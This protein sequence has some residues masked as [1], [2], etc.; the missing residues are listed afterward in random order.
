MAEND[1]DLNDAYGLRSREDILRYYRTLAPNYD[2]DFAK[3]MDFRVPELIAEA[4]AAEAVGPVLDVGAGTGLL[5]AELRQR[6]VAPIDGIDISPEMI[7]IARGKGLYRKLHQADVTQPLN[8]PDSSYVGCVSSGTFT[9]GHV[10]PEAIDALLRVTESGGFFA[11]SIHSGVYAAAGFAARFC[12]L[13]E[14]GWI[15]AFR[16][17]DIAFY[18]P[19]ATGPHSQDR[20][21]VVTFRK[22]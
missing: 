12:A 19:S 2:D 7:A 21:F 9:F 4:Y 6:G 22:V 5:A 16:A 13:E 17:A 8:L 15:T 20:G 18:G 1:F 10:G 14:D 3:A 11:F